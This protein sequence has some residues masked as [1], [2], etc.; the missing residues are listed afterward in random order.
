MALIFAASYLSA[1]YVCVLLLTYKENVVGIHHRNAIT[2]E[3]NRKL[4][5]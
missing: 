3:A 5:T 1:V 2:H 4:R